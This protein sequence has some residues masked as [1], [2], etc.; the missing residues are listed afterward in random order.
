MTIKDFID[1]VKESGRLFY[2][3]KQKFSS[4]NFYDIEH[5]D[6][7]QGLIYNFCIDRY[8]DHGHIYY[9][10][11]ITRYDTDGY[12]IGRLVRTGERLSPYYIYKMLTATIS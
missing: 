10:Y 11:R 9:I 6:W 8:N 4:S 3:A 5:I 12:L 7:E 1:S 2:E